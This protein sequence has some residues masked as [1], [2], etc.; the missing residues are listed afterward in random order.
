MPL[1]KVTLPSS[2]VPAYPDV[3]VGPVSS[4]PSK[5]VNTNLKAFSK[6]L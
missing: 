3:L 2:D 4:L 1:L 6:K 5:V